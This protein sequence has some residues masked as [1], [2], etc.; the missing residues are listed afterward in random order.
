MRYFK[1]ENKE[2]KEKAL[3]VDAESVL[4]TM[5][6]LEEYNGTSNRKIEDNW[7]ELKM[8]IKTAI[9]SAMKPEAGKEPEKKTE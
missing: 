2:S 9:D 1:Y 3:A 4:E 8:Q 6:S 5:S 7:Y